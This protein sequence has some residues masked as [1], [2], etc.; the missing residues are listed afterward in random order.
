MSKVK[1]LGSDNH[2]VLLGVGD[3][4]VVKL[5]ERDDDALNVLAVLETL[6]GLRI[7]LVELDLD[8]GHLHVGVAHAGVGGL[9]GADA[10]DFAVVARLLLELANRGLLSR[11]LGVNQTRR[12]LHRVGV[13]GWA[14]LDDDEGGGRLGRVQQNVAHGHGVD[15]GL[16]PRLAG[17]HLPSTVLARLVGELNL[18]ER[19]PSCLINGQIRQLVDYGLL[20]L[21]RHAEC[22]PMNAGCSRMSE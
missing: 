6:F 20:C 18:L 10:Q 14:V 9:D 13:Q 3:E 7:A 8:H 16:A 22:S 11:L 5:G 21:L 2:A 4:A 12:P 17:S 15:T 1:E 19:D